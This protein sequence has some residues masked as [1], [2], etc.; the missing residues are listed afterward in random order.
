MLSSSQDTRGILFFSK[1]ELFLSRLKR[2]FPSGSLVATLRVA[3]KFDK[4]HLL[5]SE[6]APLV[7]RVKFYYMDGY[8]LTHGLESALYLSSKSA[9]AGKVISF[10]H[11]KNLHRL[12][13]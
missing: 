8:F 12:L 11:N 7:E 10:F 9:T 3:D 2:L 4:S 13:T 6:V 5:S 1:F